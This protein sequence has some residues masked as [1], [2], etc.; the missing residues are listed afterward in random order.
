[1]RGR[2]DW[3]L[4]RF[5]EQ[6]GDVVRFSP[7]E[8]SF[9][10]EQAWRDIYG[11]RDNSPLEKDPAWYNVAK[12]ADQA[13]TVW[14][15][16]R[17]DHVRL[18]RLLSPAF[19][20]KALREQES[21]IRSYVDLLIVRLRE[22]AL[23]GKPVDMVQWY[24]FTTFDIIGDLA[25]GKSFGCLRGGQYHSWVKGIFDSIKIG[26][27]TR[28]M[29]AYTDVK[30]V[31]GLLAPKALREAR[32]QHEAYVADAA[33][34]RLEKGVMEERRDFLSYILQMVRDDTANG[35][36]DGVTD[37]EIAAN[38]SFFI[39][40]G[41]ETA[42][43][44]LSGI[45]YHLLKNP[46]ALEQLVTEI[47]STFA[48]EDEINL[49]STGATA[50]P[51][52]QACISEGLRLYPPAPSLL[53][54][55]TPRGETIDIAGH[56][57]PGWVRISHH[58]ISPHHNAAKY[59]SLT[60]NA[61]DIDGGRRP[62]PLRDPQHPELP[63]PRILHPGTLACLIRH[64][65]PFSTFVPLPQRPLGRLAAVQHRPARLYRE[66]PRVP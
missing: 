45:T 13:T 15:A 18:R 51:Y 35:Q 66:E 27:F 20:D 40:A 8:L 24:N 46:D 38:C 25:L 23:A 42:A 2:L 58:I 43:T 65:L 63:R 3:D 4:K 1:M 6:Y 29:S 39:I 36:G 60:Q 44:A 14:T 21:L 30:K 57:V 10:G 31:M 12:I 9:I 62:R 32:A 47:R 7:D 50:L 22:L 33:R 54:R 59:H 37:M 28:T 19:S 26:P 55:R 64:L 56:P 48:S 52:L 11:N 5:H 53:P 49:A 41:S 17:A 16:D 61:S 34:E